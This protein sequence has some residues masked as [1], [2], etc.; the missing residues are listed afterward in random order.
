MRRTKKFVA[1]EAIALEI[2]VAIDEDIY[3]NL[4]QNNYF[5]NIIT[6]GTAIAANGLKEKQ[7]SRPPT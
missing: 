7:L 6:S 5:W 4:Q 2:G 3:Q 1:A